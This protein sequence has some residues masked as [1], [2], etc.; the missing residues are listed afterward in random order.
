MLQRV[1]QL[2]QRE[3]V[4]LEHVLLDRVQAVARINDTDALRSGEVPDCAAFLYRLALFDAALDQAR[5][6]GQRHQIAVRRVDAV[7]GL[8]HVPHEEFHLLLEGVHEVLDAGEVRDLARLR[9]DLVAEC[10]AVV[11]RDVHDLCHVER[12]GVMPAVVLVRNIRLHAAGGVIGTRHAQRDAAVHHGRDDDFIVEQV[13]HTVTQADDLDVAIQEL[14]RRLVADPGTHGRHGHSHVS[15]CIQAHIAHFVR[16]VVALFVRAA[17][18]DQLEHLVAGEGLCRNV[19][20]HLVLVVKLHEQAVQQFLRKFLRDALVVD[21]VGVHV[22]VEGTGRIAVRVRLQ[23]D[24][25]MYEPEGLQR[26]PPGLR[27]LL[28]HLV[29]V[30]R[31]LLQLCLALRVHFLRCHLCRQLAVAVCII[32]GCRVGNQQCLIELQLLDCFRL[33]PVHLVHRFQ[34]FLDDALETDLQHLLIVAAHMAHAC[35]HVVAGIEHCVRLACLALR[36]H[37]RP[38]IVAHRVALPVVVKVTH[39]FLVLFGNVELVARSRLHRLQLGGQIRIRILHAHVRGT[40]M[41]ARRAHDQLFIAD[42]DRQIVEQVLIHLRAAHDCR[43]A[44]RLL[45]RLRHQLRAI[46]FH[47]RPRFHDHFFQSLHSVRRFR[48]AFFNHCLVH[49]LYTSL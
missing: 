6:E 40:R 45:V 27:R 5:L 18:S 34:N 42:H 38:R 2:C 7:I 30:L 17:Q 22:T 15:Q 13:R 31:D 23:V 24:Q 21:V 3:L 32:D 44:F 33:F 35:V 19:V 9:P 26:F 41:H 39:H 43:H 1:F 48:K 4:I 12:A 14:I 25:V 49:C 37:Q 11:Q 28:G 16:Q 8:H 20:A 46:R 29:A 10:P 47:H 36:A